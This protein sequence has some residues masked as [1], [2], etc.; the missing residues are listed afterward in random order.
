MAV[1]IHSIRVYRVHNDTE[2]LKCINQ[3]SL[4][5]ASSCLTWMTC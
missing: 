5:K 4:S 1:Q 2:K 3:Q